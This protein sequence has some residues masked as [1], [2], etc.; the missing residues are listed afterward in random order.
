M[1]RVSRTADDRLTE[2]E[3][4]E[5]KE[6][7]IQIIVRSTSLWHQWATMSQVALQAISNCSF[8]SQ[9]SCDLAE[10]MH[11]GKVVWVCV[12]R[13]STMAIWVPLGDDG[14][15]FI[16]PHFTF[17]N[18]LFTLVVVDCVQTAEVTISADSFRKIYCAAVAVQD[19]MQPPLSHSVSQV[20]FV[21]EKGKRCEN[22]AGW[23]PARW[24]HIQNS[25]HKLNFS[26]KNLKKC[27]SIMDAATAMANTYAN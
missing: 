11:F 4:K 3:E 20:N 15:L 23:P 5:K 13:H 10:R 7:I 26:F 21:D 12:R 1:C 19:L 18:H 2:E 25:R 14:R 8:S 22:D 24:N 16:F 27:H 6:E 9:I 17:S